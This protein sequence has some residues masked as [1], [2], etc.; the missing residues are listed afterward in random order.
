MFELILDIAVIV[1]VSILVARPKSKPIATLSEPIA[2]AEPEPIEIAE[3]VIEPELTELHQMYIADYLDEL[4]EEESAELA[5]FV[6]ELL[7]VESEPVEYIPDY[8]DEL[9]AEAITEAV[10]QPEPLPEIAEPEAESQPVIE[11][12]LITPDLLLSKSGK[13]LTGSAKAKR[14]A[15]LLKEPPTIPVFCSS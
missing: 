12:K 6:D 13:P 3:P 8:L 2:I 15:K 10:A 7:T 9:L 14:I 4:R 1:T 5:R 11:E